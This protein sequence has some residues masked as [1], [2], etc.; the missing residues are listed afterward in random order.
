MVPYVGL[1]LLVM[2]PDRLVGEFRHVRGG[3][4]PVGADVVLYPPGGLDVPCRGGS[5][6]AIRT[7]EMYIRTCIAYV[8]DNMYC[9][10]Y[11]N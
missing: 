7:P 8:I 6:R 2:A 5:S 10:Q 4:V 9:M 1:R 11:N 3:D